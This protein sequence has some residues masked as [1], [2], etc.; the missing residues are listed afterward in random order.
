MHRVTEISPYELQSSAG[1][2][3]CL[4]CQRQFKT[5]RKTVEHIR[6]FPLEVGGEN[7]LPLIYF[8][9]SSCHEASKHWTCLS[10]L[11]GHSFISGDWTELRQNKTSERFT[12]KAKNNNNNFIFN[13][14]AWMVE[15]KRKTPANRTVSRTDLP[16]TEEIKEKQC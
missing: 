13:S 1:M 3:L 5:K 7:L 11:V 16:I 9:C 4:N 10:L 2:Q 6:N 14:P 12:R 15:V 8:D